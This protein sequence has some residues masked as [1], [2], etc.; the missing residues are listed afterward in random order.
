[1]T[2]SEK[3][4]ELQVWLTQAEYQLVNMEEHIQHAAVKMVIAKMRAL[5]LWDAA[6]Q[7]RQDFVIGLWSG[8]D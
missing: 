3:I 7:G 1:M 8:D 2:E 4:R 5:G 6:L